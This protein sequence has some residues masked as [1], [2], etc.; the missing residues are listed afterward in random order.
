MNKI[1]KI[2][3]G[4]LT[5]L[6]ILYMGLFLINFMS[7]PNE[8]INFDTMI[9]LHMGAMLLIFGLLIFYIVNIFKTNRVTNDKRTLWAIVIFFGTVI[10]MPI[11]WYLY[12]WTEPKTEIK[13]IEK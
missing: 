6:P 11:Y 8:I 4:L 13:T 2:I 7:F 1:Q 3:I 5:I 12:I 9:K 10:A